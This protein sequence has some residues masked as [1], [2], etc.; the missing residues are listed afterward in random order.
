MEKIN[1]IFKI[2]KWPMLIVE[3]L[4]NYNNYKKKIRI[5]L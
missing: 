1:R 2:M 5:F 4:E 3:N